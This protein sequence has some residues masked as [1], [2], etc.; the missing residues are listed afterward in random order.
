MAEFIPGAS[1]HGVVLAVGARVAVWRREAAEQSR[2]A[3]CFIHQRDPHQ[4]LMRAPE[5]AQL[6]GWRPLELK[7]RWAVVR[8]LAVRRMRT[9]RTRCILASVPWLDGRSLLWAIHHCCP[10]EAD[11]FSA[12]CRQNLR[13][14][15]SVFYLRCPACRKRTCHISEWRRPQ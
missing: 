12:Q 10:S 13:Y 15:D 9:G 1:T 14:S 7:R 3:N 8:V 6:L 2:V 5:G 4:V 11:Q